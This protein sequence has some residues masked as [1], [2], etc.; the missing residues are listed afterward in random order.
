[1]ISGLRQTA[2]VVT[3]GV[4]VVEVL[5][6]E[7]IEAGSEFVEPSIEPIAFITFVA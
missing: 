1:M 2:L 6:A 3:T 4:V 7:P 5:V